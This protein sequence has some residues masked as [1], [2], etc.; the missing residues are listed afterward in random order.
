MTRPGERSTTAETVAV[1]AKPL[2]SVTAMRAP[3]RLSGRQSAAGPDRADPQPLSRRQGRQPGIG[4]GGAGGGSGRAA[5]AGDR[6]GRDLRP[7]GSP[8][9]G[10]RAGPGGPRL[11]HSGGAA[12]AGRRGAR[13]PGGGGGPGGR[14]C[15]ARF[16]GTGSTGNPAGIGN[17]HSDESVGLIQASVTRTA[18][19]RQPASSR[20]DRVTG[21][22]GRAV[23]EMP[24][25]GATPP[26]TALAY[27]FGP[28]ARSLL[29]VSL[30]EGRPIGSLSR[31]GPGRAPNTESTASRARPGNAHGGRFWR[32]CRLPAGINS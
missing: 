24:G 26:K 9:G 22:D 28:P 2:L 15:G 19:A 13:R 7:R 20:L 6:Q 27:A 5:P 1:Q 18:T 21:A 30:R 25:A 11:T 12:G 31:L 10:R 17:T 14:D 16:H 4:A 32:T 3:G 29:G 23:R 8:A